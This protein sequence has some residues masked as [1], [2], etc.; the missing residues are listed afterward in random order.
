[1]LEWLTALGAATW[2]TVWIPVAVWTLTALVLRAV[3]T[4]AST[5]HPQTQYSARLAL[6]ASLPVG[7]GLTWLLPPLLPAAWLPNAWWSTSPPAPAAE[8]LLLLPPQQL[9]PIA[10]MQPAEPL[11]LPLLL[12]GTLTA[13]AAVSALIWAVRLLRDM[14]AVRQ[15]RQRLTP[16]PAP[17]GAGDGRGAD[18]HAGHPPAGRGA[19]QSRGPGAP[20]LRHVAPPRGAAPAARAG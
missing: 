12:V 17:A 4:R 19:H 13:V 6:L 18:P 15:L 14:R 1:M 11:S 9:A 7:V 10:A 2:A 16:H 5:L 3:L 8:P 20:H